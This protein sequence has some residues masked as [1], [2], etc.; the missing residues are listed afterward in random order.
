MH[1]DNTKVEGNMGFGV[2]SATD[3]GQNRR[4]KL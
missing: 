2:L 1:V 3:R 4:G